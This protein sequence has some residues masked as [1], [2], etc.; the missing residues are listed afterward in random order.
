[1]NDQ[2]FRIACLFLEV[3]QRV[4]AAGKVQ[5]WEVLKW[6]FSANLGLATAS[7]ALKTAKLDIAFWLFLLSL[8]VAGTG[9]VLIMHY[10]RRTWGARNDSLRPERYLRRRLNCMASITDE[11]TEQGF[12]YD[13]R[14]L[15]TFT[16]ILVISIIPTILVWK[17]IFI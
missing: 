10:N 7:F 17:M 1:M 12:F 9:W 4:I 6:A 14:E 13:A 5:R 3:N 8:M 2:E 15:V 16:L 11:P